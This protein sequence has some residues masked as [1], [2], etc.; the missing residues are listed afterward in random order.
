MESESAVTEFEKACQEA[1]TIDEL[2][3]ALKD[4]AAQIQILGRALTDEEMDTPAD[5]TAHDFMAA[6]SPRSL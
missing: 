2:I 1:K 4:E 6:P 3:A 5:H